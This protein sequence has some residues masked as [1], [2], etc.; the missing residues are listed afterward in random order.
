M[1]AMRIF[2]KLLGMMFGGFITI[3]MEF[4]AF[5]PGTVKTIMLLVFILV[6]L[7]PESLKINIT[8]YIFSTFYTEKK[9]AVICIYQFV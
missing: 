5:M 3:D 2:V 4:S 8:I 6:E 9:F 1:F 7:F